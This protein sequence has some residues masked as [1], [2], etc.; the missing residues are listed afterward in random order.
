M[1]EI[2]KKIIFDLLFNYPSVGLSVAGVTSLIFS[3]ALGSFAV[4][5]M[6]GIAVLAAV[7]W[8]VTNAVLNFEK[9]SLKIIEQVEKAK[10][11]ERDKKLDDLDKLL[12]T[13]RDP[14]D[15]NLLRD[16]RAAYKILKQNIKE[17]RIEYIL[18]STL[19]KFDD[20]FESCVEALENQFELYKQSIGARGKMRQRILEDREKEI[21]EIQ[22]N[23]EWF[24]DNTASLG[25]K[26][27]D[28]ELDE[29]RIELDRNLEVARKVKEELRE[30][31]L[32]E[33][34]KDFLK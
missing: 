6:G 31:S 27:D 15:Q 20:L 29:L 1:N 23:V 33:R 16:L 12:R 10:E 11:V 8:S 13:D 7:G 18:A 26:N 14:R 3:W 9:V 25:Q 32:E 19:A 34:Y 24:V 28:K 22:R 5:F 2:K 30:T 4:G 17:G 21:L